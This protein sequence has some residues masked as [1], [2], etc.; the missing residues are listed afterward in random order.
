[1]SLTIDRVAYRGW[2]C[3]RITN[4]KLELI[5]TT[6]IG[7]RVIRFG[8]VGGQNLLKEYAEH[9][10]KR[11]GKKWRIYGGHRLWHA[12]EHPVR[13]Y[14]P[15]NFPVEVEHRG[16]VVRFIQPTEST[17]GIQKELDLHVDRNVT[18][19]HRLRNTR[20]SAVELSPWALTVMAP[21]GT[22]IVP[23]PERGEHPRDL[24]PANLLVPW[25]YTDMSDPRWT[26]GRKYVLLRQR[27]SAKSTP[28]KLGALVPDG[29]A[30]YALHGQLFVKTFP[31]AAGAN[32]PD[33]GCNFE[34]FTNREMLEV[35]TLAPLAKIKPGRAVEH[36]ETWQ[37]FDRV[38]E[39]KSDRDVDR[40]VR[41]KLT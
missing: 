16:D 31:C 17:T 41:P 21:G 35:E 4:G 30:A 39:P 3:C 38:P 7:P 33:L 11:G 27:N 9:A 14:F 40:Y 15:D 37:L 19:T 12:P 26:W 36:V 34:T 13:T 25:L 5:V 28:Q 6:D 18:I 29:W 23:L 20:R 2:K 22:C 24:L 10:G 32:Y 1:M 8:F